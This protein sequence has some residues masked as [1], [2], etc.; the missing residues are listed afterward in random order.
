M[1]GRFFESLG[2]DDE[3][4]IS[5]SNQP[6][7]EL[8]TPPPY[9]D[10]PLKLGPDSPEVHPNDSA[11]VV[12][13]GSNVSFPRMRRGDNGLLSNLGGSISLSVPG[14]DDG[15][16]SFKFKTPSG[17]NHRLKAT[18]NIVDIHEAIAQKLVADPFFAAHKEKTSA[19]GDSGDGEGEG[20]GSTAAIPDPHDFGIL[21][22]DKD[23]DRVAMTSDSDVTDAVQIARNAG[24]DRVVLLL[25]GGKGWDDIVTQ[26]EAKA[27]PISAPVKEEA[28]TFE[29]L[30]AAPS[31]G[32]PTS[33]PPPPRAHVPVPDDIMGVPRDL[34]LPASIGALAVV[35]I[36]IFTI[37][38]LSD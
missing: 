37:S 31:D 4:A 8:H 35:I 16:Y 19:D 1:W 27:T 2:H 36:A 20:D 9:K 34:L 33:S 29:K 32:T 25:E 7:S 30:E 3:S 22:V 21:Y 11:S 13:E 5:G 17:V 23:G 15:K 24:D 38:R 28:A 10:S 6:L 26:A 12:D 14:P 18:L